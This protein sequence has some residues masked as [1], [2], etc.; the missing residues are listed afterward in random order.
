MVEL[1]K[2]MVVQ[3]IEWGMGMAGLSSM[4]LLALSHS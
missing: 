2:V 1:K 3:A 4:I